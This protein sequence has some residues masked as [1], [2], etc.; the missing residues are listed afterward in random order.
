M[1]NETKPNDA[2]FTVADTIHPLTG[3]RFDPLNMG[4]TKR[5]YFAAMAMQGLLAHES[6]TSMSFEQTAEAACIQADAL[7]KALNENQQQP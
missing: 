3:E 5:E 4:L 7:I 6:S 2:A 1:S